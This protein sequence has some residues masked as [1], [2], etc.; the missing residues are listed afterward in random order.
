MKTV[1]PIRKELGVKTFFNMLGPLV[2]PARPKYQMVGVFSLELARLYAYLYQKSKTGYTIV[3]AL[4]GYD[5]ISLT[6]DF[7]TFSPAG[8]HIHSIS[9]MGF[10]KIDPAKIGGGSTV[11]R[12]QLKSSKQYLMEKAVQSKIMLFSAMLRW[13]SGRSSR[14]NL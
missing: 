12:N 9:D 10:E 3:H 7:K 14:K 8:E 13:L 1:A 5:E 2:N 6:C 4:E 11:R